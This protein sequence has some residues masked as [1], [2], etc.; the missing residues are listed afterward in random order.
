MADFGCQTI[1][2]AGTNI[3]KSLAQVNQ[4]E[5]KFFCKGNS[6]FTSFSNDGD[7]MSFAAKLLAQLGH[8]KRAWADLGV[9]RR[10]NEQNLHG[11][12][13]NKKL[14]ESEK[15]RTQRYF[16]IKGQGRSRLLRVLLA[17]PLTLALSPAKP[18]ERGQ[19]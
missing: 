17:C 3:W 12:Y 10:S 1:G 8:P 11:Y 18:V 14:M 6:L 16:L 5:P 2:T 9:K 19:I 15:N 4:L 13:A 7:F